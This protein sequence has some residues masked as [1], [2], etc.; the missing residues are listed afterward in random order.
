VKQAYLLLAK[1][2]H[3]DRFVASSLSDLAPMVKDL[4]MSINEA[5]EVLVDD[6]RRAEYLSRL[7]A[8]GPMGEAG[9]AAQL[10]FKKGEACVKVHDFARARGFLE[11]AVR[12]D[13]HPEYQATLAWALALDPAAPDWARAKDLL[14]IALRDRGCDRALY[15]AGI[16]ARTEGDEVRAEA[17]FRR[18]AQVNPGN[19]DAAREVLHYDAKR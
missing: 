6:K 8:K 13:P 3:P 15:V 14:E 17:L 2:F 4:F 19:I 12:A 10:D 11:A 7:N 9:A 1:Q 16:I 5:Y 18:A